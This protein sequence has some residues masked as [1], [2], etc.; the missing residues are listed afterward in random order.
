ML[1]ERAWMI[2]SFRIADFFE[3]L[4]PDKPAIDLPAEFPN[5]NFQAFGF[6]V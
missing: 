6:E 4:K 5:I 2:K 3:Y 1:F